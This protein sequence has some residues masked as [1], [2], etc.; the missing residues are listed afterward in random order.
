MREMDKIREK[1]VM[2]LEPKQVGWLIVGWLVVA[3]A[4]FAAGY[5]VG[6]DNAPTPSVIPVLEAPK[7][8]KALP[9]AIASTVANTKSAEQVEYTYDKRLTESSPPVEVYQDKTME[10]V[11]KKR[12]EFL[13]RS[14]QGDIELAGP[15]PT[16]E[17][18]PRASSAFSGSRLPAGPRAI[19]LVRTRQAVTQAANVPEEPVETEL[20]AA[21]DRA[22]KVKA[23]KK[24]QRV[25]AKS[26]G[27]TI[28][29]KAFRAKNEASGFMKIL[30]ERGYK[31]YMATADVE[32]RGR[33]YRVRLGKFRSLDSAHRRQDAFEKAENLETIVTRL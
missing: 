6:L 32:G 18:E 20:E 3:C 10:L 17:F 33:F 16:D 23:T 5:Q 11:A 27:F 22:E 28:Q 7:P 8:G 14:R 26:Q 2:T 24:R 21:M 9:S 25:K 15:V 1:S 13:E 19:P 4:V 29:I 30:R 12:K 31:P